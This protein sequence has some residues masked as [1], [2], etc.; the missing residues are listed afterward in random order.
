MDQEMFQVIVLVFVTAAA[1]SVPTIIIFK[2]SR[3]WAREL[4]QKLTEYQGRLEGER[5]RR[6]DAE[7]ERDRS[8]ERNNELRTELRRR[9]WAMI[10]AR[11]FMAKNLDFE[12]DVDPEQLITKVFQGEFFE[13]KDISSLYLYRDW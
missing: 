4:F 13:G 11:D 9:Q 2:E 7:A 12:E 6:H 1:V 3:G 5:A 8:F 10:Y